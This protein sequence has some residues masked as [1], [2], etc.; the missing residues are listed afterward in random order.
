MDTNVV[1]NENLTWS[2]YTGPFE[3]PFDLPRVLIH[4]FGHILGLGHPNESGQTVLAIMNSTVSDLDDLQPDDIAGINALYPGS[5]V[6][7]LENP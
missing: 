4:E 7:E 6:G 1:V 5:P 2:A 3:F